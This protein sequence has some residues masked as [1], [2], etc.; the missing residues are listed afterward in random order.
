MQS[1]EFENP[2]EN[3][4]EKKTEIIDTVE[5][6]YKIRI[7]VYQHLYSDIADIF[8]EYIHL[9]NPDEIQQIDEDIKTNGLRVIN[10]LKIDNSLELLWTFQLFYYN[11]GRLPLT[12]GLSIV[13]DV[14]V[15][16]GEEKINLKNLY[17]MFRY[18]SSLGLVSIQFL[19]V[20]GIFFGAGVRE[21]KDAITELYKNLSY[22]TLSVAND[23]FIFWIYQQVEIFHK[24]LYPSK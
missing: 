11:N 15:P 8:Y 2:Y 5:I 22:A 7:R 12:N 3:S 23:W 4:I 21:T 24:K 19:G 20:L 16:G 14:D 13:P 18:T 17:E 9:L 1:S 6:N 10:L